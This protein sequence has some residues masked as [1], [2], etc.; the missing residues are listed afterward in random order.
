MRKRGLGG[1][2]TALQPSQLFYVGKVKTSPSTSMAPS[3]KH[4][5]PNQAGTARPLPRAQ[6]HG[7][8]TRSHLRVSPPLPQAAS[9]YRK[10]QQDPG[11][12]PPS[13]PRS[14]ALPC[15]ARAPADPYSWDAVARLEDT[16][17]GD[18]KCPAWRGGG[19]AAHCQQF[20][21]PRPTPPGKFH[22]VE[23]GYFGIWRVGGKSFFCFLAT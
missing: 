9:G 8:C 2:H 4:L 23:S 1:R 3:R 7:S 16:S 20:P 15:T 10:E 22:P 13:K 5:S 19:R 21:G 18:V 6:R 17:P 12:P 11:G 14:P